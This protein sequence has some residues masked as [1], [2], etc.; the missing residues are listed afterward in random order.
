MITFRVMPPCFLKESDKPSFSSPQLS[1]DSARRRQWHRR[2]GR[3]MRLRPCNPTRKEQCRK[4]RQPKCSRSV[5]ST[6][7]KELTYSPSK[8]LPLFG[9]FLRFAMVFLTFR[10]GRTTMTGTGECERQYLDT[11]PM[12]RSIHTPC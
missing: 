12:P 5:A 1:R 9:S 10:S 6:I 11:D 3:A 7:K 4:A 2:G 8:C